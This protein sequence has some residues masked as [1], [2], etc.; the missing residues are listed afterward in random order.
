MV[1]L[2]LLGGVD[3]AE[4]HT[5]VAVP[6]LLPHLGVGRHVHPQ[7]R[8]VL[9]QDVRP[10]PRELSSAFFAAKKECFEFML[11]MKINIHLKSVAPVHQK[12]SL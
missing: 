6:L 7:V 11:R 4:E 8:H 2:N 12:L 5:V 10:L 3:G 9:H 1:Q